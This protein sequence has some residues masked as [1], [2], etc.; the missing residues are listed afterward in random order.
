MPVETDVE[1]GLRRLAPRAD[2]VVDLADEPVVPASRKL[3]LAALAL[4]WGSPTRR[5]ARGSSRRATSR[6]GFDGPKLAVIGTGKRTGKT[7]VAGHW[8]AL[9]REQRRRPGDRLHGPRRA[10]RAAR[11]PRRRRR[12]TSCSRSRRAARTPRPTTSRTRC[13]PACRRSAAGAWA[14]ASRASRSSRTCR[15]ARGSPRRSTRARSSSRAPARA[16]RRSRWTA[17]SASS[18]PGAPEPFAA[19]RLARADLVL[20]AEGAV[21]PPAGA[22][23]VRRS[24][25]SRSR[26]VPGDARVA[27]FTTGADRGATGSPSRCWSSTNLARRAALGRRPRAR[28]RRGLRR[29][30]HRAEGGGD[31]H[32]RRARR[33]RGRARRLHPQPAA[34]ASTTHSSSCSQASQMPAE[35]IVVHK[36]HGLPYSKGLMAQAISATGLSPGR[37]FELARD[38]RGAARRRRDP[39]T[40]RPA[41]ARRGGAA[42]EEDERP[43]RRYATGGGSTGSSARWWCCSAGTTGVGKSTLATMLAAPPRH[44]PRDRDGRDPS[45]APGILLA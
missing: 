1:E 31:R 45:G 22:R 10:G 35:T 2:A 42:T 26:T 4:T 8:A 28:R 19:Y 30:P 34:S 38:D 33:A 40:R 32:G 3:R 23:R 12:S 15:R 39:A 7:A 43:P 25:P 6:V 37:A 14:A 5:R 44:Q 13:S 24:G 9:L 18:A 20:A 11:W 16:S 17:R 41:R 36:G 21:D 29:L 27:V